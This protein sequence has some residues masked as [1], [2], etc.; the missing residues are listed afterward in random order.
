[1]TGLKLMAEEGVDNLPLIIERID[2][3]ATK[4]TT[5]ARLTGI[6]LPGGNGVPT[7]DETDFYLRLM[8]HQAYMSWREAANNAG[9]PADEVDGFS[10]D[11][12]AEV[13]VVGYAGSSTLSVEIYLRLA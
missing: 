5:I 13:N 11:D 2:L 8:T 10:S 6:T 9:G 1:M 4:L 7:L 3:A 12:L